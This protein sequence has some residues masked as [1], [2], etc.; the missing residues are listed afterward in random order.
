M[1]QFTL[2]LT[3]LLICTLSFSCKSTKYTPAN[4]PES[5]IT[6]GSGGGI[7]GLVTDYTL[8]ENGQLFKRN[9]R[10]NEFEALPKIKSKLTKQMFKNYNFLGIGDFTTNDPGNMS[11]FIQFKDKDNKEHKITWN[12]QSEV[13]DKVKTYYSLL[14]SLTK[15]N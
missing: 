7:T 6:F 15:Q 14:T 12:D 9:S 11:Y 13:D 1:K 8:L 4:F 10:D 2:V 3:A 5:Q